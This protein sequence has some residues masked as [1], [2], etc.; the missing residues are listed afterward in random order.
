M[1]SFV[2]SAFVALVF[3]G[4]GL[5]II[6]LLYRVDSW[7][8][9][10]ISIR[11]SLVRFYAAVPFK[12]AIGRFLFL[13]F[14]VI[15]III[16]KN[17]DVSWQDYE[18]RGFLIVLYRIGRFVLSVYMMMT[19][20]GSGGLLLKYFYHDC[21]L[22][23]IGAANYVILGFFLGA[24]VYGIVL[25]VVGFVGMLNLPIALLL[26]VP[27]LWAAYPLICKTAGILSRQSESSSKFHIFRDVNLLCLIGVMGVLFFSKGLYPGTL[28]GD[29]WEHYLPYYREV[30]HNASIW[31]NEIW[32][33][34][35]L[36]K[37]AGLF[38]LGALLSDLLAVQLVSSCFIAMAGVIVFYLLKQALGDSLWAILGVT[39]F[40]AIYDGDFFKHHTVL[41][42]YIAFLIWAAVQMAHR[43]AARS[44]IVCIVAAI[45]SFYLAFYIPPIAVLLTVFWGIL[46]VISS[47]AQRIQY[48]TRYFLAV[49]LFTVIGASTAS[50]VNYGVTGL[51]EMTPIRFFWQFVDREKF[52]SLFGPSGVLFFLNEQAGL[53][54]SLLNNFKN[55]PLWGLRIFRLWSL[56]YFILFAIACL[57]YPVVSY[58]LHTNNTIHSMQIRRRTPLYIILASLILSVIITSSFAQVSSSYR[59]FAFSTLV[60]SIILVVFIKLVLEAIRKLPMRN[61]LEMCLLAGLS[62]LALTQALQ[63]VGPSRLDFVRYAYGSM[64][65]ADVLKKADIQF[66]RAVKLSTIEKIRQKIGGDTRI[67]TLGSDPAP[68]YSFPGKGVISEPSYTMGPN[69]LNLVFGEPEPAKTLLRAANI[70]YFLIHLRSR[71]FTGL[72]FSKL[73]KAK[74]LNSYFEIAWQD[75]EAYL[76][77][78]R[79]P[80]TTSALPE[81]LIQVIDLKQ[82]GILFYPFSNEFYVG[83]KEF[84]G[85]KL[86]SVGIAVEKT[87]VTEN[88][89]WLNDNLPDEIQKMLQEEIGKRVSL[90]KNRVLLED[91]VAD[92]TL[93]LRLAMPA[94]I[95]SAWG[96]AESMGGS[97]ELFERM[98]NRSIT[99]SILDRLKTLFLKE[100]E[101]RLGESLIKVLT[102]QDEPI[103]FG[104]IYQS[105]QKVERLLGKSLISK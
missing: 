8:Q 20:F 93:N 71:L 94:V 18:Q 69:Y 16:L 52:D 91:L 80:G 45:S 98:L 51:A 101:V 83:L 56:K 23:K 48:P 50:V 5:L 73:F 78:W 97:N 60:S 14:Y 92:V 27:V 36:S 42:G 3:L 21:R 6:A 33:H 88:I 96:K 7:I 87:F 61:L 28:Q 72:A 22:E 17:I 102:A 86:V 62:F 38:F 49:A 79:T 53:H 46:S 90:A 85:K 68:G 30:I 59:L 34:F 37:G 82:T 44:K 32:Y 24:S 95:S 58:L 103:P 64:S 40:F 10:N 43:D 66:G 4:A 39:I 41:T 77:T 67:M 75:G 55:M 15:V 13:G 84:V 54:S 47:M 25:T 81:E 100:G 11:R 63:T 12:A 1:E 2:F 35:Y 31:P 9:L 99:V 70:N 105:P 57:L 65:F 76:L 89:K 26:T 74:N 29:V 19:C 104:L